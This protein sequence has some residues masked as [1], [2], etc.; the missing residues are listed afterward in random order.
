LARARNRCTEAATCI[1]FALLSALCIEYGETHL[2]KVSAFL[3][4]C[5]SL[6]SAAELLTA[7]LLLSQ[8]YIAGK[9]SYALLAT[10]YGFSALLTL[11]YLF[12]FPGVFPIP[13]S[14]AGNQI[15]LWLWA[16]RHFI[17]PYGV[18]Y[19]YMFDPTLERRTIP[20]AAIT[21]ALWALCVVVLCAATCIA[22]A[23]I[24][25]RNG[26]PVLIDPHRKFTALYSLY[27]AP[28]VIAVNGAACVLVSLR[29]RKTS[30]LQLWIAV[31]L[32]ASTLDGVLNAMS[33]G[34]YSLTWYVG[35]LG[36]LGAA[37]AVLIMLLYEISSL[38]RRLFTIAGLDALTGLSNRRSLDVD[39]Q[40][41]GGKLHRR[42]HGAALLLLDL[43]HFKR[44]NDEFGHV[45]GD[46][47]L[48][49]VASVLRASVFRPGDGVARYGGEE[50]VVLLG[51]TELEGATSVAERIRR[52]VEAAILRVGNHRTHVTVSIG[53]AH[54]STP[55]S[56][57]ATNLL[58]IA[59]RA[60]Y[61]AKA[62][63]RNCVS[64]GAP[65]SEFYIKY[66]D[67]VS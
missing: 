54:M 66:G 62:N 27:V 38:Y 37:S 12:E 67:A 36:E 23:V 50:F 52:N 9:L 45:A 34:A 55:A 31:S 28:A 64:V 57:S 63:G 13:I 46:A 7:F 35:K 61:V 14:H 26:L 44:Y 43:D 56:F 5:A 49:K 41:F 42:K 30:P 22:Y 33:N 65:D 58:E 6:W 17:F 2:T 59:D 19:V 32:F 1:G 48:Q 16:L 11:P 10:A 40:R 24:I 51:D 4:I 18:A 25:D 20:R 29:L 53:I 39:L 21:P 15:S 3:P 47:A 8:F 60:L